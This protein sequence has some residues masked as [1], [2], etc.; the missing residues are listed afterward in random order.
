MKIT[1]FG[2]G[3]VKRDMQ[4]DEGRIV[5]LVVKNVEKGHLASKNHC[6]GILNRIVKL[7]EMTPISQPMCVVYNNEKYPEW[8]GVSGVVILAESHCAIHCWRDN[9]AVDVVIN[10][11]KDFSI[12]KVIEFCKEEF[13]TEDVF[14]NVN[15]KKGTN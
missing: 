5:S 10:S 1:L 15:H 4:I 11:C 6:K 14:I 7:I 8:E 9:K 2:K 13:F 12:D 3:R